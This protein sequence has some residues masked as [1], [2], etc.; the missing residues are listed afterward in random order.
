TT[1]HDRHVLVLFFNEDYTKNVAKLKAIYETRFSQVV[2]IAPDHYGRL[3]R[4]YRQ[5]GN[6]PYTVVRVADTLINLRRRILG[7]RN[8]HEADIPAPIRVW[9]AHGFKYYF[10]DFFW[11]VRD[12]LFDLEV[13]WYWFVADDLL[14]HP[15]LNEENIGPT[16]VKDAQASSVIC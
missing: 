3:D 16:L 6:P 7:R 13:D 9:R 14:L 10:Q 5:P 4:Y 8:L 11:Q 15:N 12:K 2:C 1:S